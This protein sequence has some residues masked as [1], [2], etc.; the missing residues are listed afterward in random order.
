MAK[1]KGFASFTPAQDKAFI[2][3]EKKKQPQAT[4]ERYAIKQKQH[5]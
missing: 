1:D 3:S 4:G 2:K 5:Q